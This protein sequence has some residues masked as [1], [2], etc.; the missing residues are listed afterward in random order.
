[1]EQAPHA[2]GRLLETLEAGVRNGQS[3]TATARPLD[4]GVPS[5][6]HRLA[7]VMKLLGVPD[8]EGDVAVRLTVAL[9]A[10]TLLQATDRARQRP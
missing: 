6:S 3:V 7:R 2:H 9:V 1:M 5:V 8:L 4:V 10:R